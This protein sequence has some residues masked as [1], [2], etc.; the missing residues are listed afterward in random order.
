MIDL[1]KVLYSLSGLI[2]VASYIPQIYKLIKDIN[3]AAGLSIYTWFGWSTTSIISVIYGVYVLKDPLFLY[4][5]IAN[6]TGC[7]VVF[8]FLLY[9]NFL[10][11]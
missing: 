9:H 7:C 6:M 8:S 1:I 2:V 5:S 4:F 11:K 3:N 10:K